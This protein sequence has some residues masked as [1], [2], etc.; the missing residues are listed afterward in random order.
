[1][2][3]RVDETL[4]AAINRRTDGVGWQSG[5]K[6]AL[7]PQASSRFAKQ[8]QWFGRVAEW[9]KAP[10]LKT[11]VP[12]RVPWVRIPPLPPVSCSPLFA[13]V[14]NPQ[15]SAFPRIA[16]LIRSPVFSIIKAV[17]V[18]F[19]CEF[20]GHPENT[21]TVTASISSSSARRRAIGPVDIG[22]SA[23]SAGTA[24]VHSTMCR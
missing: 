6:R 12:A 7:S 4:Q 14:R 1:M 8:R 5:S 15:L 19:D 2:P 3:P 24:S 16:V 11:G 22:S 23:R 17:T 10:V 20:G 9:F 18:V 21:R 13:F